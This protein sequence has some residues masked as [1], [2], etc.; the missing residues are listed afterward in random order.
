MPVYWYSISAICISTVAL[1]VAVKNYRRKAGI[2]VRGSFAISSSRDCDDRY[3]SD[4]LIENLKDRAITVF[5]IGSLVC[6]LA[7]NML[8]L[9]L[10]RGLQG[11]GGGGLARTGGQGE[12]EARGEGGPA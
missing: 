10:A 11:L 9:I 7:P 2:F 8:A 5:S 6:A 12:A 4:V 1:L 3:V